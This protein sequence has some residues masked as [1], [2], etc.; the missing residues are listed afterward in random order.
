VLAPRKIIASVLLI[1]I[2]ANCFNFLLI[3]EGYEFNKA[4]ISSVLCSNKDKP[5]LHCDGK[6]FLDLKLKDLEK[7]NKQEQENLKRSVESIAETETI[8]PKPT[9]QLAILKHQAS[10]VIQKPIECS[11]TIFHPPA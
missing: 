11:L 3:Q 10:W 4:Y 5:H 7:K 2:L 9:T 6:C 1:G 8:L